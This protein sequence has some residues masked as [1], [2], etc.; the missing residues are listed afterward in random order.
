[1]AVDR[2]R[3]GGVETGLPTPRPLAPIAA[4]REARKGVDEGYEVD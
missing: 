4:K 1:M 2:G 3:G